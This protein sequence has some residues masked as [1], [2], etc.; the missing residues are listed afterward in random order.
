MRLYTYSNPFTITDELFWNKIDSCPHFCVSQTLVQ[1]LRTHY[2]RDLF[3]YLCTIDKII[4]AIHGDWYVN[5]EVNI[6]QYVSFSKHIAVMPEGKLKRSFKFNQRSL[7]DAARFLLTIGV[8][9]KSFNGRLSAEQKAFIDI[10]DAVRAQDYWKFSSNPEETATALRKA[11]TDILLAEV[12][13]FTTALKERIGIQVTPSSDS[14]DDI[15]LCLQQLSKKVDDESK[16]D[17]KRLEHYMALLTAPEV[18]SVK[19]LVFHGIHQFTPKILS[20]VRALEYAGFEVVFLLNYQTKYRHVYETWEKVYAWVKSDFSDITLNDQ[21]DCRL[22]GECIG[23]ILE[24]RRS[25][26]VRLDCS[27]MK[28]QN[29]TE[30]TDLVADVFSIAESK[31][32][33]GSDVL[34]GMEEQFYGVHG[35]NINEI[36]KFYFP[37]QFGARH[38]LAYPIGQFILSLYNMW[39]EE[40]GLVINEALLKECFSVNIWKLHGTSTPISIYEK[41]R[42]YISDLSSLNDILVRLGKLIE[43]TTRI[44]VKN[45][46]NPIWSKFSFFHCDAADIK[47]FIGVLHDLKEIADELFVKTAGRSV[48][49]RQH[50]KK[51]IKIIAMR[52][53]NNRFVSDQERQLVAEVQNRLS[54]LKGNRSIEGSIDDLRETLHYYL[55]NE[56]EDDSANW[57]V[58]NFEQIDGGVL[59]SPYSRAKTYHYG[60][61]SDKNMKKLND[62]FFPWPLTAQMFESAE[63]TNRDVSIVLTSYKEYRNYLRYCIFYGTYYLDSKKK[64]QFSFIEDSGL[65]KDIPYYILTLLGLKIV[66]SRLEYR[67]ERRNAPPSISL[68]EAAKVTKQMDIITEEEQETYGSCKYRFMLSRVLEKTIYFPDAFDCKRLYSL[69]LFSETWKPNTGIPA[70]NIRAKMSETSEKLK[71]FFPFFKTVDFIDLENI[72]YLYLTYGKM[73]KRGVLQPFDSIYVRRKVEFKDTRTSERV[74]H[75]WIYDDVLRYLSDG[76]TKEPQQPPEQDSTLCRTCNQRSICM[77]GYVQEG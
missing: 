71:P 47:Y 76:E 35:D 31:A 25:G 2:G 72:A 39:S 68:P 34:S 37:K 20:C 4:N 33:P 54:L 42:V 66:P 17:I 51:L 18:E 60:L 55:K 32:K 6:S 10:L 16:R 77:W 24:G 14:T 28:F 29:K 38:F 56:N 63:G 13:D 50:F 8:T 36:L 40:E 58:R 67:S 53:K 44:D 45:N 73:I 41:L 27:I 64:I 11:L 15:Y 7:V 62:E 65:D 26:D 75:K 19:T 5:P 69:L 3:T 74:R 23:N 21:F 12:V 61:L 70:S 57:I 1:G 52:M 22:L 59:L 43:D 48:N 30:L 49:F 9:G 46:E